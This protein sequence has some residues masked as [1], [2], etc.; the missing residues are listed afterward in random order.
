MATGF[1]DAVVSELATIGSEPST[2]L[3]LL[4]MSLG[5]TAL[6]TNLSRRYALISVMSFMDAP[7]MP[8]RRP[9]LAGWTTDGAVKAGGRKSCAS[10]KGRPA[11][12]EDWRCEVTS[13][14]TPTPC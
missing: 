12:L 4:I 8:I 6:P 13:A 5:V 11:W 1:P 10:A 3:Q 14:M 9:A 2:A 7:Y